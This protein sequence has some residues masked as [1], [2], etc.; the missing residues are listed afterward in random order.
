[1]KTITLPIIVLALLLFALVFSYHFVINRRC[2]ILKSD[3]LQ[4]CKEL[5][6]TIEELRDLTVRM[7]SAKDNESS[8]YITQLDELAEKE[9][10]IA[11]CIKNTVQD[12]L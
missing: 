12:A 9:R 2:K 7:K 1:M 4:S 5:F 8:R 3:L 6:D 10:K 11:S